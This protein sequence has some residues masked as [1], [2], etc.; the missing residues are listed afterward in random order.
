M[1]YEG[2]EKMEEIELLGLLSELA[3]ASRP[4]WRGEGKKPNGYPEYLV[5]PADQSK[6]A[7]F[8]IPK[9]AVVD[10]GLSYPTT[11][12]FTPECGLP[13]NFSAPEMLF[14]GPNG[15]KGI[16]T[17][18]WALACTISAIIKGASPFCE[19]VS[20]VFEDLE[21][22]L[23]PLPEPYRADWKEH[24]DLIFSRWGVEPPNEERIRG[25]WV[26]DPESGK[27]LAPVTT[28]TENLAAKRESW[29]SGTEYADVLQCRFSLENHCISEPDDI[30]SHYE[31]TQ[32]ISPKMVVTPITQDFY[33]PK[34][35]AY[36][37]KKQVYRHVSISNTTATPH[38]AQ[39]PDITCATQKDP[40][41]TSITSKSV[42]SSDC[43]SLLDVCEPTK[44]HW[45]EIFGK[46]KKLMRYLQPG[47]I[48][49]AWTDETGTVHTVTRM[50]HKE[51]L[52]LTDLVRKMLRYDP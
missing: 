28:S 38:N 10:F 34:Y 14:F 24:W 49:K 17:D 6:L 43:D 3:E 20:D 2:V 4:L 45:S 7:R 21:M 52:T 9:I 18:I 40:E 32:I 51:V 5:P 48:R 16:P 39:H 29:T 22:V 23:G 46:P 50:P 33:S 47:E 26:Q 41:I 8:I 35:E 37:E 30:A 19:Y 44:P 13:C 11:G 31:R 36:D 1:Q 42:C 25:Y 15:A 27:T 12:G